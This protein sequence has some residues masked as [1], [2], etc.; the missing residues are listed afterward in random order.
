M[1]KVCIFN[2]GFNSVAGKDCGFILTVDFP[3][4]VAGNC[5]ILV[6]FTTCDSFI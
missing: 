6:I 1:V 4:Q 5:H 2:S 3:E